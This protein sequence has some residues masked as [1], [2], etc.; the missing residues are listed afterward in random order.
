MQ[1]NRAIDRFL[2]PGIVVDV[3]R[4]RLQRRR[5]LG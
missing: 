3:D 5:L 1:T 2:I 4:D